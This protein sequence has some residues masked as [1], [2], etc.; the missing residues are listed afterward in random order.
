LAF[1][2]SIGQARLVVRRGAFT[3]GPLATSNIT[4]ATG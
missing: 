3:I 4:A 2:H 1:T